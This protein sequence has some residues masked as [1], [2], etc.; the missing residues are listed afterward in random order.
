MHPEISAVLKN[1]FDGIFNGDTALLR[2]TF[3][4]HAALY[5]EIKGAQYYKTLDHY[6]DAVDQRKSPRELNE[7]YLMETVSIDVLGD[8]ASAK[9]HCVMLGFNY[10]DFLSLIRIEG[11]WVIVNKLFTHVPT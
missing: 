3:H 10:V 6:L 11:K 9:V 2:T 1:Y 8:V 7:T 4:P 5:G